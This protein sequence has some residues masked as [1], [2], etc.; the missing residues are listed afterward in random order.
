MQDV[1]P[2]RTDVQRSVEPEQD[3]PLQGWLRR[4]CRVE[5]FRWSLK[6]VMA[7]A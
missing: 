4:L 5:A 3:D 2:V 7:S 1:Q 6:V